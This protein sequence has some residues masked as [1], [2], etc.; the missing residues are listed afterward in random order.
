MVLRGER[1]SVSGSGREGFVLRGGHQGKDREAPLSSD[2]VQLVGGRH[3]SEWKPAGGDRGE[4]G[5][6][7]CVRPAA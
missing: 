7:W 3:R 2:H 4:W 5:R 1:R 6:R